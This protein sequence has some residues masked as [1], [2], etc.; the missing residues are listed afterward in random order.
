MPCNK[1]IREVGNKNICLIYILKYIW[2]SKEEILITIIFL[3]SATG[4]MIVA[5]FKLPSSTTHYI[6]PLFSVSSSAGYGSLPGGI[7]YTSFLKA[8]DH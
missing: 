1:G 2:Q 4:H 6:F 3:I 7:I 5:G 8:L